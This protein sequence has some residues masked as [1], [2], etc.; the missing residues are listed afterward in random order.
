M[1]ELSFLILLFCVFLQGCNASFLDGQ[2]I[3]YNQRLLPKENNFLNEPIVSLSLI[4][5]ASLSPQALDS[6]PKVSSAKIPVSLTNL[7]YS[8]QIDNSVPEYI[9][10]PGD[11]IKVSLPADENVDSITSKGLKVDSKGNINF[12]YLGNFKISNFTANEAEELLKSALNDFYI[13]PKIFLSVEEFKS[14]KAYISGNFGGTMQGDSIKTKK[15]HLNDVPLTIIDALDQ[16]GVTFNESTPNP[17]L[18]LKRG[19]NSHIVDLGFITNNSNP[20]IYVKKDD[21]LYLPQQGLQKI[22]ITG[23]VDQDKML[24]FTSTKTLSDA[25]M[26]SGIDKEIAN[27]H[28]I[29]VL[30]INQSLDNKLYGIAYRLDYKSP[31][32]LFVSD[33]FYLLDR[34]IIF[35]ST[36][37]LVRWNNT[38]A[39]MLTSLDFVNL[40]KSYKPINS[41]VF[42]TQ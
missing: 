42:R 10:G 22:Y 33:K 15:V 14:N 21:L 2:D 5:L 13:N 9:I 19:S 18:I 8:S 17:F 1:K 34:D 4:E 20:N 39:R 28:E 32:T 12:P 31:T 36:K 6:M 37:K 29:Y 7:S 27:L 38:I 11:I 24:D 30:R 25:L 23:A 3:S 40:W 41:D 35:V 26:E 16:V